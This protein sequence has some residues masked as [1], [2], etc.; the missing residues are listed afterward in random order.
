MFLNL[1]Y[2]CKKDS[3]RGG[4]GCKSVASV[5]CTASD[6]RPTRQHVRHGPPLASAAHRAV[7]PVHHRLRELLG[8][9]AGRGTA[10]HAEH[11][12]GHGDGVHGLGLLG[13]TGVDR[14]QLPLAPGRRGVIAVFQQHITTVEHELHHLGG[15]L[16]GLDRHD[17]EEGIFALA[18]GLEGRTEL[19]LLGDLYDAGEESLRGHGDEAHAI[20]VAVGGVL[21]VGLCQFD[22]VLEATRV[23]AEAAVAGLAGHERVDADGRGRHSAPPCGVLYPLG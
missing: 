6:L 3:R 7:R 8:R 11:V 1:F 10:G 16:I 20:A 17:V 5:E 2:L 19:G 21:E 23:V 15:E 9:V 14:D 13:G 4:L 12:A 22:H 18:S